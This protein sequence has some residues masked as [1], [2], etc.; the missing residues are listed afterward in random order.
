MTALLALALALPIANAKPPVTVTPAAVSNLDVGLG[1]GSFDV[2]VEA[3]RSG[4]LP[5]RL[6]QLEYTILVAGKE[7]ASDTVQYNGMWIGRKEPTSIPIHVKFTMAQALGVGLAAAG[8][9]R[10]RVRVKGNA[11]AR[12]L[13]FPVTVAFNKRID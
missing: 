1:G 2:T 12:V 4:W 3:Q 5:I 10:L 8:K 6:R 7:F 11:D 13:V 9:K